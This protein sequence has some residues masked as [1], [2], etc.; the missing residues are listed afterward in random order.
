[1]VLFFNIFVNIF[2][3]VFVIIFVKG[4]VFFVKGFVICFVR[5]VLASVCQIFHDTTAPPVSTK[6]SSGGSNNL[7][8]RWFS[9]VWARSVR[10]DIDGRVSNVVS[11]VRPERG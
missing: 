8:F 2:V 10:P 6:Y 3:K 5:R 11:K 4:F 9:R 7:V 1:M